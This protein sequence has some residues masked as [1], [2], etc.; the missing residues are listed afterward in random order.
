MPDTDVIIQAV[1]AGS[2]RVGYRLDLYDTGAKN[3]TFWNGT[4]S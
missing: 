1:L 2:C 3:D 4:G